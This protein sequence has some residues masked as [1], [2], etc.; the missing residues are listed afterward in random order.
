MKEIKCG[1]DAFKMNAIG[2]RMGSSERSSLVLKHEGQNSA[3]SMNLHNPFHSTT[4][5]TKFGFAIKLNGYL[6][7]VTYD[8]SIT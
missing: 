6:R 4:M 1:G 3:S 5:T 8:I 2:R 7:H